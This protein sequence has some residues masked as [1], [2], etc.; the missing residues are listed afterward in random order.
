MAV[1]SIRKYPDPILRKRASPVEEI[2]A[3]IQR[4]IDDMVETMYSIPAL[5]LAA[6]QV[7]SSI[8]LF[9]VDKRTGEENEKG[10]PVVLINP[11]FVHEE[12]ETYEEEG[13][14]SVPD[15]RDKVKRAAKVRVKG[16]DRN[17]KEIEIEAE[18]LLAK[19]LQH[20]MDHLNG[21]LFV[22]RLS[23]LKREIFKQRFKKL[24]KT[25][26]V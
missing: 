12:G 1:L 11:V 10:K 17:G 20:E 3:G 23:R 15:Y 18:G 9:V 14:L 24:Y 6:P 5:G 21:I 16:L 13:C 25:V 22:D 4:L 26:G 19:A 8:R 7:G 2:T